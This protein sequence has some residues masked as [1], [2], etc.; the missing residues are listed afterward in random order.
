MG[1][2]GS[3]SENVEKAILKVQSAMALAQ[4]L[5]GLEDAGRAFTQ[6]KTVAVNAFNSIKKC[7][8]HYGNRLLV[9]TF[10]NLVTQWDENKEAL[11]EHQ[12]T[13]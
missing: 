3:E 6:L 1:L 4:G 10:R 9:I 7:H 5:E 12:K 13:I 2:F 8:W 11:V